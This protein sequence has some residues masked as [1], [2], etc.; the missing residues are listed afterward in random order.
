MY[1]EKEDIEVLRAKQR[2]KGKKHYLKVKLQR[3][4]QKQRNILCATTQA[5]ADIIVSNL[6]TMITSLSD[7]VSEAEANL[8]QIVNMPKTDIFVTLDNIV[9]KA[10][11]IFN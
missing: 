1:R 5:K 8:S 3:E 11:H 2:E 4:L 9:N 7:I 10:D 6:T